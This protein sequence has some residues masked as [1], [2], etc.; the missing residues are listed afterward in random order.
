MHPLMKNI[1][2]IRSEM[3]EEIGLAQWH[4]VT[5]TYTALRYSYSRQMAPPAVRVDCR[6]II[7][8]Q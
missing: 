7:T 1:L 8:V 6:Q 2:A 4:P 3:C 5:H